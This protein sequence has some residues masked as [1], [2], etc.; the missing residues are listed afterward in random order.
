VAFPRGNFILVKEKQKDKVWDPGGFGAPFLGFVLPCGVGSAWRFQKVRGHSARA[1][2][3]HQPPLPY[4]LTL[5]RGFFAPRELRYWGA[6]ELAKC[7]GLAQ[8]RSCRRVCFALQSTR[9]RITLGPVPRASTCGGADSLASTQAVAMRQTQRLAS[10]WPSVH[11]KSLSSS[12]QD[13]ALWPRQPRF[14]SWWGHS[15]FCATQTK[16]V[17]I[18]HGPFRA[19]LHQLQK[20]AAAVSA[21]PHPTLTPD[22]TPF[23]RGSFTLFQN[24]NPTQVW[25]PGG[26]G[27][28]FLGFVLP[29][30]CRRG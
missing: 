14:N 12:G 11:N 21:H 22:T 8:P 9:A 25:D 7:V 5:A 16:W 3:P 4:A 1:P 27:A 10:N 19:S 24:K 30:C 6:A 28:P 29:R 26:L 18:C 17:S 15:I 13:V 2:A 23:P 20:R